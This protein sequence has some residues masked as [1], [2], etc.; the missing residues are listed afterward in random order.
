MI[1]F[2]PKFQKEASRDIMKRTAL[3]LCFLMIFT[4]TAR[5]DDRTITFAGLTWN[6]RE[7]HGAPGP[8]RWSASDKSVWVDA[9]GQLHMKIRRAG[10]LW[11]CAEISTQRS[12][13]YGEYVFELAKNAEAYDPFVV[14]GLFTYLDDTHEIDIEL[15]RWRV[16]SDPAGQF[17]VQPG[18]R[19]G[20]KR[21]FRLGL[22][23]DYS[24]HAFTWREGSV[25][26]QSFH[27]HGEGNHL[28]AKTQLIEEWHCASPDVP[29]AGREK[30]HIN[31]WLAGGK[32]PTDA[33]EVELIIKGVKVTKP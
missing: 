9:R 7:G 2:D 11:S 15:S 1:G 28:P 23:G 21:R 6:V 18:E 32:P 22:T 17:V 16:A 27:G 4:A 5:G 3:S 10:D 26:F 33:R 29:K 19:P 31:F 20:N 13:G 30:L 8:N 24:T 14:V 12:L 25:H